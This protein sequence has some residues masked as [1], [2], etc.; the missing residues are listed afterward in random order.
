MMTQVQ[1]K[2]K[3]KFSIILGNV[4]ITAKAHTQSLF[5]DKTDDVLRN[6]DHED[7]SR[8]LWFESNLVSLD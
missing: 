2:N 1:R 3:I 5:P 4:K 6:D 8:K 7:G